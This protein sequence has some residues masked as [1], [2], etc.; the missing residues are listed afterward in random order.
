MNYKGMELWH[1]GIL[2]QRWGV[3]RF[4]NPDGTLTEKGKNRI[5]KKTATFYGA[6]RNAGSKQQEV[7]KSFYDSVDNVIQ[8]YTGVSM[9]DVKGHTKVSDYDLLIDVVREKTND[10]YWYDRLASSYLE[11]YYKATLADV[12]LE[13]SKEA[14]EFVR[15]LNMSDRDVA[16]T[17][18]NASQEKGLPG[19]PYYRR[20]ANRN[21]KWNRSQFSYNDWED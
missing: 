4:Q 10:Y 1:Y 9:K 18:R 14:I 8:K 15:S 6:T 12:N 21:P 2:G 11:P 3:R 13:P 19:E 7:T 20:I 5:R 17:V 16:E